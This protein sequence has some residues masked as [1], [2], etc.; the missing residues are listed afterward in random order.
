MFRVEG[1]TIA[2]RGIDAPLRVF[3]AGDEDRE[4]TKADD[5]SFLLDPAQRIEIGVDGQASVSAVG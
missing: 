3:K 2:L 4:L 1:D 5:I